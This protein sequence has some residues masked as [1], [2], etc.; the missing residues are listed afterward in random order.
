MG[1]RALAGQQGPVLG[2]FGVQDGC[3]P[4][5]FTSASHT[6]SMGTGSDRIGGGETW[7]SLGKGRVPM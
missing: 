4:V 7:A 2:A 5:S 1:T 6:G 3:L